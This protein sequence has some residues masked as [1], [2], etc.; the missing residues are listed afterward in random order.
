[1]PE[2]AAET[3]LREYVLG[4]KGENPS[5]EP[6]TAYH[7]TVTEFRRELIGSHLLWMKAMA[8]HRD[9]VFTA[10][11]TGKLASTKHPAVHDAYLASMMAAAYSYTL[12]AVI[13]RAMKLDQETGGILAC[14]ADSILTNGGEDGICA[15]VWP[16]DDE[17]EVPAKESAKGTGDA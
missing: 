7:E 6:A 3:A 12:A 16:P 5:P 4:V 11:D 14:I 9:V 15:D 1:M 8:P 2:T 13:E 17:T 10:Q